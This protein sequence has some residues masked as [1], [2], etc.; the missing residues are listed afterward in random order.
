MTRVRTTS[1]GLRKVTLWKAC[2]ELVL[3]GESK[4]PWAMYERKK[5]EAVMTGAGT[6]SMTYQEVKKKQQIPP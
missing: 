5:K 6:E 3:E 1:H 4:Q 2:G